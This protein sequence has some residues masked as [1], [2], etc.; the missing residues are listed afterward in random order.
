VVV[1]LIYAL[2]LR[3][4]WAPSGLQKLADAILHTLLP[5][6]FVLWWLR[7][8]PKQGLRWSEPVRWLGYPLAYFAFSVILGALTGRYLYPFAD[9]GNLGAMRVLRNAVLLLLLFWG[10]GMATV[11][12]VRL[13]GS[14]AGR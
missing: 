5:V 10:L 13:G 6:L 14:R 3:S 7:Y 4:L 12:L 8:A 2:L 11:T 9:L 1:G